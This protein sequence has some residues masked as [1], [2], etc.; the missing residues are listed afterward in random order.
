[1][2]VH[3]PLVA[4]NHFTVFFIAL[5]PCLACF[6]LV[7]SYFTLLSVVHV[8]STSNGTFAW[9]VLLI[10]YTTCIYF[11][12][13]IS[14]YRWLSSCWQ[15]YVLTILRRWCRT[16]KKYL[17]TLLVTGK[18]HK[19]SAQQ[20]PSARPNEPQ[21]TR[22]PTVPARAAKCVNLTL[23]PWRTKWQNISC[24]WYWSCGVTFIYSACNAR[25]TRWGG[26]WA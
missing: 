11:V 1:M 6:Q 13:V 4:H 21:R 16:K 12:T 22:R 10:F 15:C 18:Q 19:C 7:P 26:S 5:W 20:G 14:D 23:L 2:N 9:S 24:L 25:Y 3:L 17:V 8:Y